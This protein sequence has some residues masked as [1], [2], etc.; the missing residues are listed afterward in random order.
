ML[1]HAAGKCLL[2][3]TAVQQDAFIEAIA[4]GRGCSSQSR[5]APECGRRYSCADRS[6]RGHRRA[7]PG[8][9]S[10]SRS[11]SSSSGILRK[12]SMRPP[13]YS[14]GVRVSSK[15]TLPS[16]GSG[17]HL[18]PVKLL[19]Q[20]PLAMF[21]IMKP[22]MLT[23]LLGRRIGRRIGQI[24]LLQLQMPSCPRGWRWPARRCAYPRRHSPRSERPAGDSVPFSKSTF[25]VITLPPG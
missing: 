11:R 3:G 10:P 13:A 19:H 20:V 7:C 17:I 23:G 12:P 16:R 8:A 15:V 18:I 2:C 21:S 22:A 24:Q 5:S 9:S 4:A 6:G 25:M 14:C 1:I